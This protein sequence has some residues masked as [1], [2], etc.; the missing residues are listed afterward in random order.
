MH[1]C[2]EMGSMNVCTSRQGPACLLEREGERESGAQQVRD[3][4]RGGG[5]YWEGGGCTCAQMGLCTCA[6][7]E[8]GQHVFWENGASL[9]S[10]A[11]FVNARVHRGVYARVHV[12]RERSDVCKC[13]CAQ[14]GL[15]TCAR[16]D[17]GQYMY[18]F[19][20]WKGERE[21]MK[22]R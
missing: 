22:C 19:K 21:G 13:T 2:T 6:Q 5:S 18:V 3:T 1:V 8:E 20:S 15:C 4:C 10:A 12:S 11:T 9:G 7:V 14:G 16:V 17:E